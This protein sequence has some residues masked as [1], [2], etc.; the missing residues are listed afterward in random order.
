M[1]NTK[2][3]VDT[4][5]VSE[6]QIRDSM[7]ISKEDALELNAELD[8]LNTPPLE[9][10]TAPIEA[11]KEAFDRGIRQAQAKKDT[12]LEDV[13]KAFRKWL[14]VD[15]IDRIDIALAVGINYRNDSSPIWIIIVSPSGDW[16]SEL[17][18]SFSGLPDIVQLDQITKN[19]LASGLKDV[20]DLGAGL[21]GRKSLLLFPDMGNLLACNKDDKKMILTQWRELYDG[22]INKRTGSGIV[23]KYDDCHVSLLAG[24][25]PSIRQEYLL[26]QQIGTRE[27]LYDCDPD[28]SHNKAKMEMAWENEDHREEMKKDLHKVVEDFCTFHNPKEITI[29]KDIQDFLNSSA[30]H[31]SLLRA[32]ANIEWR[33]GELLSEATREVP[34]RLIKQLKSIWTA[35]KSLDP[36]YPDET[37]KR[38]ITKI[39]HSSGDKTRQHVI[40]V[41][42]GVTAEDKW[43]N[44]PQIQKEIKLSRR[45]IKAE[46]EQLWFLGSLNKDIRV[47]RIGASV[48]SD[49]FGGETERGGLIREV[50]YYSPIQQETT[51][52]EL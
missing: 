49:G 40:K 8:K 29:T 13:H 47:E 52:E 32:T 21:T 22:R 41:F 3:K 51:Q 24:A 15:D 14:F 16:K 38:I 18:M 11:T 12:T 4:P 5:S 34:T 1:V 6:E 30:N 7:E 9:S 35:L 37:A 23:K 31:L 33:T 42:K 2:H 48:V 44:I 50:E 17:L 28:P 27:L 39:I 46:C 25:T 36:E 43:L 10:N 20:T 19:T 45:V 26:H